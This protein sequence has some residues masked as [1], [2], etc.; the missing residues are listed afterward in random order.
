MQTS[1][2]VA[3]KEVRKPLLQREKTVRKQ[4]KTRKRSIGE[5]DTAFLFI[6]LILLAFGLI[7]VFS[8]SYA[9]ALYYD[10]DS[11]KYIKKQGMFAV[12]GVVAMMIVSKIDYRLYKKFVVPIAL[13]GYALLV[14]VLFFEHDGARRW[15]YLGPLGTFQPSEYMKMAIIV[16]FSVLISKNYEKMGTMRYGVV[17]FAL[18]LMATIGLVMLEPHL[19]GSL[20]IAGIGV[21][22]M[23]VGG[24]KL[25]YFLMLL[26]IGALGVVGIILLKD[27]S[28]MADRIHNWLDPFSNSNIHGDVWQTCQSLI[29]IGS[30]GVMGLGLG[31]SQQKYLYLPEPQNDFIFA[32]VC[33]ELG[34]IGAVLV[35][36]LFVLL[37]YRGFSIANQA[38]DKFGAMLAIGITIQIGLQALLN[39]G[40]VTNAIPNTGISLPF[41]SYGG[42][43]LLLQLIEMGIVLNISRHSVMEKP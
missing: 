23:Y 29:A 33:E 8:A 37:V 6:V 3:R 11:L 25:R 13:L 22:M 20:I 26:P 10:H 40:V 18:I 24:T 31:G 28:Y 16:I 2:T 7:M 17:P 27:V 42:S 21:I 34:M 12:V 9:N 32:I 41:F 4:V 19:S 1:H 35:I 14:I 43:A 5:M 30:G 38:P 15:I 39:I 36:T